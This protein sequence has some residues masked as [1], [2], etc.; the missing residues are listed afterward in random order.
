MP[1]PN[2]MQ[3]RSVSCKW[4]CVFSYK[5]APLSAGMASPHWITTKPV[6]IEHLIRNHAYL[7]CSNKE[8]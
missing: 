3:F 5:E 8:C 4:R 6:I 7:F 2:N 1:P